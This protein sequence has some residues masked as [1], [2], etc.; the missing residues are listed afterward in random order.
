MLCNPEKT[1]DEIANWI[2]EYFRNNLP[3]ACAVVG[4]SGGKDSSVAAALCVEALGRDRV[5]GVL[6]PDGTQA[7][8]ADA[9]QLVQHLRI[10]A[11]EVNIAPITQ[12]FRNV[13]QQARF[14][15]QGLTGEAAVN[16]P[17]RIRM[18]VLYAAAQSLPQGGLVINTCNASEDYVGY[19]TKFGDAAGDL[20][21]LA[22]F[23]VREV[24]Q[25]G[26]A[27]G[28]PENLIHKTPSD[29]LSG[30]SD[31]EKLGFTY[32]TLDNY[33]ETGVC[34]D[35]ATLAAIERLHQRNLHKLLPLP[36]FEK[37]SNA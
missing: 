32:E 2:Q 4:I 6:M 26:H 28:L 19:S 1:A 9:R 27:L 33:V 29:G 15:P 20:A 7:D 31:E 30:M 14:A 22:N 10:R 11:E 13:F 24:L 21:P 37:D 12:A 36:K 3:D 5:L 8:I 23:T 16:M 25:L 34:E 18:A 35:E 17:P